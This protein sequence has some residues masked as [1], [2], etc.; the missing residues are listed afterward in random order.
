[1][2]YSVLQILPLSEKETTL[3]QFGVV[4]IGQWQTTKNGGEIPLRSSRLYGLDGVGLTANVVL[5]EKKLSVG[6][7][8]IWQYAAA[9]TYEG[10]ILM[11]T[12]AFSF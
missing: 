3:L 10:K 11:V 5:P 1:V 12:G 2:D 4:G 6:M 7:R 8:Y 9:S